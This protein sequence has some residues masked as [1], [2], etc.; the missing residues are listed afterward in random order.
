MRNLIIS[1]AKKEVVQSWHFLFSVNN[2]EDCIGHLI[3]TSYYEIYNLLSLSHKIK[4]HS[5]YILPRYLRMC[6]WDILYCTS[7]YQS[8]L[9]VSNKFKQNSKVIS[10]QLHISHK[11]RPVR[12][13]NWDNIVVCKYSFF[14]PLK[15]E[16]K[17]DL[18]LKY[19]SHICTHA[20]AWQIYLKLINE[21]SFN[22]F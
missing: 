7:K 21:C 9:Y 10:V 3:I 11:Q 12:K 20:D 6:L 15:T 4:S 19:D 14:F 16:I 2:R 1:C 13:S 5:D 8:L 17:H 18:C 22:L